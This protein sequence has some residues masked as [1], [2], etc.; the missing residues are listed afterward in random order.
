MATLNWNQNAIGQLIIANDKIIWIYN[1]N[2]RAFCCCAIYLAVVA[3]QR[4]ITG[5]KLL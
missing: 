3:I 1:N 2:N 4:R 5:I